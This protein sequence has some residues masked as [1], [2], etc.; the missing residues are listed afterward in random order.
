[1]VRNYRSVTAQ[2]LH[3]LIRPHGRMPRG[4]VASP[5]AWRG[6]ELAGQPDRWITALTPEEIAELDAALQGVRRAGKPLQALAAADF[7][8]P[9]LAP[10]IRQWAQVLATGQGVQ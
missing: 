9:R 7:P 8:L 3:Y 10:R 5:A 4:P 1:M 2:M 6:D